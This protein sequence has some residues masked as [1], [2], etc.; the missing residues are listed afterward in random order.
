[1]SV[2]SIAALFVKLVLIVRLAAP[3]LLLPCTWSVEPAT[4]VIA[5]LIV[6]A[7]LA[8]IVP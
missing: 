1:M 3:E 6:E 8:T 7:P 2:S 4:V 5:P